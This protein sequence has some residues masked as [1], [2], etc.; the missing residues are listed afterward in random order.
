MRYWSV[1]LQRMLLH[2]TMLNYDSYR[3][4]TSLS[5]ICECGADNDTVDHFLFR[6]TK[7]S[8]SRVAMMNNI[9]T[10]LNT[11]NVKKNT[12]IC[13]NLLLAP[14]Y[15]DLD[16]NIELDIKDALFGYLR[17]VNRRL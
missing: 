7:Y 14:G 17:D 15:N 5:P 4:G 12:V 1:I 9:E 3:T 11:S 2:D 16:R 6:C 8:H 10:A 13:E